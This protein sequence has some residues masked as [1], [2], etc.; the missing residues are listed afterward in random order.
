LSTTE[1]IV[2]RVRQGDCT[3]YSFLGYIACGSYSCPDLDSPLMFQK[4]RLQEFLDNRHL[5]A[6]SFSTLTP[7]TF[8]P[9]KYP[10]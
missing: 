3:G 9:K 1:K 7:A 2:L 10:R 8:T 5:K 4:D 6:V